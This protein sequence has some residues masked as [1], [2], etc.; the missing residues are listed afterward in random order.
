M[1]I[2]DNNNVH[3]GNEGR[4]LLNAIATPIAPL[5]G[6]LER[7][8]NNA[9]IRLDAPRP[10]SISEFTYWYLEAIQLLELHCAGEDRQSGMTRTEV[11]LLCRCALSA[12]TLEG[13]MTLI[14]RYCAMLAPRAG[15][16]GLSRRQAAASFRFESLRGRVTSTSSLVD[17]TG[18]FAYQQL[19]QWLTGVNL[20]VLQVNIGPLEREDLLPFLKLF[21]A[22]VLSG[23]AAYAIDYPPGVLTLPIART[24][25]EFE[26]FFELFP[27]ALFTADSRELQ[28]QVSSL[29]SASLERGEGLPTQTQLAAALGLS[30]STFRRRL[31]KAGH[32]FSRLRE[33]ALRDAAERYLQQGDLSIATIASRLGFSDPGAFRRAFRQWTGLAPSHSRSQV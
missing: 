8:T 33:D 10:T 28:A 32:G 14:G 24:A 9:G 29:L 22:P 11:E 2:L 7:E 20:P 19:F 13:A 5:V 17:I 27:C 4:L 6:L 12:R 31:A 18:L 16:T 21:G 23:G 15:R 3:Y 30:L 1:F 26:S 25:A